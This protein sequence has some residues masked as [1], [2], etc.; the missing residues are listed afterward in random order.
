MSGQRHLSLHLNDA[1]VSC[2]VESAFRILCDNRRARY[3][4]H[5]YER[6][7]AGMVLTGTEVKAAR[8]GKIQ[9]LDSYAD[10]QGEELWLFNA[11]ISHYSHGN[12]YNHEPVRQRKLLLHRG[13]IHKLSGKIRERGFTLVPTRLYLKNGFIKCEI[14]LAKGKK[15]HD[16]RATERKREQN[17]EAREA[18][19]RSHANN[20]D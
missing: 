14:A 19:R 3:D 17:A 1:G 4:Y 8:D 7:E 2:I 15:D 9:L 5:L 10:L 11:H 12:I 20:T 13:E 16:K 6:F 18:L